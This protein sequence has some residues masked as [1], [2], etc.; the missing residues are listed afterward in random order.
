M[1]N[2]DEADAIYQ[3]LRRL[4]AENPRAARQRFEQLLT[5]DAAALEAVLVRMAAPGE[6]RLR[7]LVANA[8]RGSSHYSPLAT[9]FTRW[10]AVETDEFARRAIAAALDTP[11][12]P[13]KRAAPGQPLVER[14]LVE[15]YRYVADRMSHELRNALLAPKTRLLQLR[16]YADR[17]GD[18]V[19]RSDLQALLAQLDDDFLGLGRVVNFEPD[20]PYFAVRPL[21]LCDWVE[22]MN[23]EYARRYNRV[24]LHVEASPADR[25]VRVL[26]SDYLLRLVFW[27]LWLNAHQATGDPCK[28]RLVVECIAGRVGVLVLDGGS[29]FSSEMAEIAFQERFS[30][31]GPH[32]GR[33]LLEVQEAVQQLQGQAQL[34]EHRPGEL[35]VKLSFPI[36]V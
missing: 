28:I 16:E 22:G 3:A 24:E 34:V 26:G 23:G 8:A 21:S 10:L 1:P 17:M 25:R 15:L 29:G 35:R 32:R 36:S 13:P 19:L 7:Q 5:G 30:K 11:P 20:D 9:H 33:G 2:P 12:A 27:N 6:G 31:N 4:A 14:P 18:V